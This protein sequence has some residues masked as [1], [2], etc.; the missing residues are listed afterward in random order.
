MDKVKA[1]IQCSLDLLQE[2]TRQRWQQLGVFEGDF[3][4]D[5]AGAVWETDAPEDT[6]VALKQRS[7]LT[8]DDNQRCKLHDILRAVALKS[9]NIAERDSA[10]LRHA[11]H[12]F[13]LMS[14]ANA[15][16]AG[17]ALLIGHKMYELDLH[18]ISAAEQWI[19]K[20]YLTIDA[21]RELASRLSD[22]DLSRYFV[23][24][25]LKRIERT[26]LSLKAG[27]RI[28]L[29]IAA[30]EYANRI[31]VPRS[32]NQKEVIQ[33]YQRSRVLFRQLGIKEG[34]AEA[35][36][37]LASFLIPNAQKY[38]GEIADALNRAEEFTSEAADLYRELG[39]NNQ[40]GFQ[41]Q[42][43]AE[44]K[45]H[46]G[47]IEEAQCVDRDKDAAFEAFHGPNRLAMEKGR[48]DL[49]PKEETEHTRLINHWKHQLHDIRSMTPEIW[50]NEICAL[51][52]WPEV[53]RSLD[54]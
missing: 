41:L 49:M 10:G 43:L 34:L 7:L 45:Y 4:T 26:L 35:S 19:S 1:A 2:E 36:G 31:S 50:E 6:L 24:S 28:G 13:N 29:A 12:F 9:L 38:G 32:D 52:A 3:S 20:N 23:F 11:K 42:S 22:F 15:N 39:W 40:L 18:N 30:F 27:N 53:D 46:L 16:S 21:A 51:P 17:G 5:A 8:T 14:E 44:I 48:Y 25:R 47:K 37:R 33:W 54:P